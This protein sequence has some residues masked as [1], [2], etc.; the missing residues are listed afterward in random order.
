M[1]E[2]PTPLLGFAAY[3]GTG[4][5][6]LLEQLLPILRQGGIRVAVI[7]HAHH[8]FDIDQPG[9][10]SYRL[11]H[12]GAQQMLI[13]SSQRWALM[14][15]NTMPAEPRLQELLPQ[16]NH[17]QLD[18]VLVEGFKQEVFRKIELHR[19]SMGKDTLF[20]HDENIVAIATDA[21]QQISTQLP[22][23]DINNVAEIAN[24]ILANFLSR[25]EA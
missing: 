8:Q 24:F 23:L 7:K 1:I 3:S 16:L 11:R 17:Q 12:A 21:A 2:C 25:S 13:A 19:P 5:T 18:L 6:T 10:D 9:K 22:I 15:E 20:P 4:K 14:T